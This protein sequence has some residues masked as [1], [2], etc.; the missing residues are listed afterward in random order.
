MN[1]NIIILLLFLIYL[2]FFIQLNTLFAYSDPY[3]NDNSLSIPLPFA[4]LQYGPSHESA[5]VMHFNSV[6]YSKGNVT[7]EIDNPNISITKLVNAASLSY[8]DTLQPVFDSYF[9]FNR[10]KEQIIPTV[11]NISIMVSPILN[12]SQVQHI[13]QAKL[14][15]FISLPVKN[16]NDYMPSFSIPSYLKEGYYAIKLS[17]YLS[18]YD[19]Y[20]KYSN[21]MHLGNKTA[22][23]NIY[24]ST[25]FPSPY[26]PPTNTLQ[27]SS[28]PNT[29]EHSQ[30]SIPTTEERFYE[31]R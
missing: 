19:I 25:P 23:P 15:E 2:V 7:I 11:S 26:A 14:G 28:S 31:G 9:L 12:P 10:L 18:E 16:N 24:S 27:S 22:Y 1:N 17:V 6:S 5:I 4:S 29:V 3:I 20:A 13:T 8:D 21:I 30:L